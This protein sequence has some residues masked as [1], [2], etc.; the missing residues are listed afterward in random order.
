[1]CINCNIPLPVSIDIIEKYDLPVGC[2]MTNRELADIYNIE[3]YLRIG[4][5]NFQNWWRTDVPDSYFEIGL[6]KINYTTLKEYEW[7]LEKIVDTKYGKIRCGK[8]VKKGSYDEE[9]E[10]E[11]QPP[12]KIFAQINE[13]WYT[14]MP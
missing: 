12:I 2:I 4:G 3:M 14:S 7:I 5:D 13:A 11:L 9:E 6:E 8:I 10:E 1:M